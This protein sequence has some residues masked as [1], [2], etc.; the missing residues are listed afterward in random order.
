MNPKRTYKDSLFRDIFNNK[1]RLQGIYQALTGQFAPLKGIKIT[2]LRGTFFDD[3]KNDISFLVG[4]LFIVLLE[5]QSTLSPNMP[6]RMLWY[7]AKLYRQYADSKM[8]YRSTLTPLPTPLFFVFYNGTEDMPE[9][10]ELRLSDAF[11]GDGS[12]LELIV[13]VY[14]INYAE[15]RE[16]LERCRDLKCY[17]IF[18]SRVR[19]AV[20]NGTTLKKA[21]AETI[22]YC[23]GNDILG[24][25][26]AAK[27][28]K[29]VFDM[30]SFKWD[31]EV[32]KQVWMEEAQEKGKYIGEQIGEERGAM[33]ATLASIRNLMETLHLT[34]QQAMDALK[35]PASEQENTPRNYKRTMPSSLLQ[36]FCRR[37]ILYL[38][39][40]SISIVPVCRLPQN[41]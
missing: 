11:G 34:M 25:Y 31:P 10:W 20:K 15:N 16:I 9:K 2:T 18:V 4:N 33:Q 40:L 12:K 13:T 5:H 21:I 41:Q 22:R 39:F 7:V 26:F 24:D 30:V 17:S 8:P 35:I 14:N 23:K 1:K 36:E 28:R 32:A 29:E 27:E 6:I 37:L 19:E 38:L 3:I